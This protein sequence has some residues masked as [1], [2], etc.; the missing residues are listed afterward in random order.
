MEAVTPDDI[1][2]CKVWA[3][4]SYV[5]GDPGGVGYTPAAMGRP[6]NGLALAAAALVG[7]M[8]AAALDRW[9]PAPSADVALGTEDA[10]AKGLQRRELPPRLAQA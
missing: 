7:A 8:G 5:P 1:P 9:A 4:L 3:S 10:F 2:I 6:G